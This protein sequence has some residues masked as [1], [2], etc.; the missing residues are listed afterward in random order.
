MLDVSFAQTRR[1][2]QEGKI[3]GSVGGN[4][5]Y[6]LSVP[7]ILKYKAERGPAPAMTQMKR[8]ALKRK[9]ET[10]LDLVKRRGMWAADCI[11]CF[12]AGLDV[13]DT[14][15]RTELPFDFVREAWVEW[16]TPV[17]EAVRKKAEIEA[18]HKREAG[19]RAW[20][21]EQA[22]RETRESRER[23]AVAKVKASETIASAIG[24]DKAK[25]EAA[26]DPVAA[27]AASRQKTG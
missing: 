12:K 27:F 18:T 1:L 11:R 9:H 22:D 17:E 26:Y 19:E 16:Q 25:G 8:I 6:H 21:K 10:R 2:F 23:V 15:L 4:G 24:A 7:D 20:R 3:G 14:I 13:N 5:E